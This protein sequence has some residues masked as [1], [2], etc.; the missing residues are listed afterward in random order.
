MEHTDFSLQI[1]WLDQNYVSCLESLEKKCFASPWSISQF[2]KCMHSHAFKV[3][4][5]VKKSE[6]LGYLSFLKVEEEVEIVNLAVQPGH[7][8]CGLARLLLDYL[9][10]QCGRWKIKQIFLE[11]RPSNRAAFSLY[12]GAGFRQ[13][14]VRRN[15]YPDNHEDAWIMALEL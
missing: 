3:L 7:R 8:R 9:V 1:K 5:A 14:G 10:L 2:E 15:Y 6:L 13:T 11:V 4:G 12:S